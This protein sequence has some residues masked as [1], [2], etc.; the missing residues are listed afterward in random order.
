MLSVDE[1]M[2]STNADPEGGA[3]FGADEE[4]GERVSGWGRPRSEHESRNKHGEGMF[5]MRRM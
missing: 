2:Y 5:H 4:Q 3:S 1:L